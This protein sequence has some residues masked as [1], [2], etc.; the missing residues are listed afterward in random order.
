MRCIGHAGSQRIATASGRA[1]ETVDLELDRLRRRGLVTL[2][3][4]IFGGWS[5][6]PSGRGW[7][8]AAVR[9]EVFEADASGLVETAYQEFLPL[10]G[11]V[12]A[13]CHDCQMRSLGG[14]PIINDHE[15]HRYDDAVLD[16]LSSAD[17][18]AQA[19]CER[20]AGRLARF[21]VYGARLSHAVRR[22]H[23]GDPRYV[24]DDLESYHSVWFQLHEDLLVTCGISRDDERARE[25]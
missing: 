8:E 16:R 20:L 19:I 2:D 22:A 1:L 9:R 11:V 12:M 5:L 23:E 24:T 4:G 13:I 17:Q 3:E 7:A 18:A 6:T 15:D 10:N 14:S 21:S 25:T